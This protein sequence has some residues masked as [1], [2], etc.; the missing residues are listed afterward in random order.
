MVK[1]LS[2]PA[3]VFDAQGDTHGEIDLALAE[4]IEDVLVPIV[5]EWEQSEVW[6]HNVDFFGD[7]I[8]SLIFRSGDFPFQEIRKLQALLTGDAAGFCITV[9]IC[10]R[11]FGEDVETV[12]ALAITQG[13][14]VVTASLQP[15]VVNTDR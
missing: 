3:E 9:Q 4:S 11:L 1:R 6:F 15:Y 8:R 2:G 12:G 5:G 7:G 13:G 14:V 10:N